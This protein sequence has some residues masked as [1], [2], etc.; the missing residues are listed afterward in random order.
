MIHLDTLT[1]SL[2]HKCSYSLIVLTGSKASPHYWPQL[3]AS[4]LRPQDPWTQRPR[5]CGVLIRSAFV[6]ATDVAAPVIRPE[7][8]LAASLRATYAR[9]RLSAP[10]VPAANW[11]HCYTSILVRDPQPGIH[12]AVKKQQ[13]EDYQEG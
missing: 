9:V 7:L 4:K 10:S 13:T 2:G 5:V 11:P 1:T 8:L 6:D 12:G 3:R